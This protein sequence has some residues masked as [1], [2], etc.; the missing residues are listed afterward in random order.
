M[1]WGDTAQTV[2]GCSDETE[3]VLWRVYQTVK[4]G[5]RSFLR[6]G[7]WLKIRDLPIDKIVG[8]IPPNNKA[9]CETHPALFC[10]KTGENLYASLDSCAVSSGLPCAAR[11][12]KNF[13]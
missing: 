6:G 12:R 5:V 10:S 4:R 1:W 9:E 13:W 3:M 2:A 11:V 7:N 8:G